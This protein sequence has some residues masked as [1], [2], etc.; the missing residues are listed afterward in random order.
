MTTGMRPFLVQGDAAKPGGRRQE[1]GSGS[2]RG[3]PGA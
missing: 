2:A 1:R 3:G